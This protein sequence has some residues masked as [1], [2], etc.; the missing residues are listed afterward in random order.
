MAYSPSSNEA[1][2]IILISSKEILAITGV[3][4][5]TL[6]NYIALGILSKPVVRQPDAGAGDSPALGYFPDD[7][8]GR[9]EQ[10]RQLKTQG[11]SMAEIVL[12][13]GARQDH[14]VSEPGDVEAQS[15]AGPRLGH[16]GMDGILQAV[17]TIDDIEHPA[18]MVNYNFQ[19]TWFNE[20]AR[21]HILGFDTPPASSESRNVFLLPLSSSAGD[22]AARRKELRSMYILLAKARLSKASMLGIVKKMDG[23]I[24]AMVDELYEKADQP[25]GQL[26]V[27]LPCALDDQLGG[28]ESWKV[29]GI[30][31]R[32]GILIIHTPVGEVDQS[33]LDFIAHRDVVVRNL[34][35]RQLP[36]LTPLSVLLADL[37]GS[38]NICAE[39][40]PDEYFQLINEIWTAM[41]SIF[42]R[43]Y[44]TCGKH[45][46]D[47]ML[48]YFFPLP[49]SNYIFN[50]VACAHELKQ[51]MRKI[52][53]SWQLRKNWLNEL[54]LNI[55]LHEGTEWLG[56]F[57]SANNVEFAVLGDTIN[58]AARLSDFARSGSIWATK[59][60]VS[61]LSTGERA[62]IEF[63]ISRRGDGDREHFV[64]SS[65][66]QLGTL[67][68]LSSERHEKLREISSLPVTEIREVRSA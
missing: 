45:V 65:Y 60:L 34:L 40:P 6:N 7:S 63:G 26:V 53:K 17:L 30:Y 68:D 66:S 38:V 54:Y 32:E 46:G 42:R 12:K 13:I 19:L 62:R 59:S 47:G 64:A 50:A 4:R 55:G 25:T 37:Q 18:Y 35:R 16:A 23:D 27:E 2:L 57:Q 14:E 58:H 29:Y 51:E 21:R 41:G 24:S 56:T 28:V 20:P 11:F 9:I 5:A 61:K 48:Y 67:I 3:S 22:S 33:L 44:G 15:V 1:K 49:D 10:V 36:V 31:F 43:Y 8:L 39:L 52:S